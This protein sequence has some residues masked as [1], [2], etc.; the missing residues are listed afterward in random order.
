MLSEMPVLSGDHLP[1]Q[2]WLSMML[3]S[4]LVETW[5]LASV[6]SVASNP[7]NDVHT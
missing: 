6:H 1:L 3:P 7:K 4:A 2:L 5:S